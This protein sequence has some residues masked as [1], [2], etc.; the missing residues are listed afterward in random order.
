[1]VTPFTSDKLLFFILD[2]TLKAA[3][4]SHFIK[5]L[6]ELSGLEKNA[7]HYIDIARLLHMSVVEEE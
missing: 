3:S 5:Q 1:M 6:V 2:I 7:K 4:L